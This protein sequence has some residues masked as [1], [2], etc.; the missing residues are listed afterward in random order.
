[1]V[2]RSLT[3]LAVIVAVAFASSASRADDGAAHQV[4]QA[5]PIDLGTS[6]GNAYDISNLYCC[7]GTLGALVA[8]THGLYIL[9]NNHVL[10]RTN[11]GVA[12]DPVIQPGMVDTRCARDL[13]TKVAALTRFVPLKFN[14]AVNKV[15]AAIARIVDGTVELSGAVLDIGALGTETLDPFVGLAV[16][17]SGRTTGQT[18]GTVQAVNV[19]L[20]VAYWKKCGQGQQLAYFTN[21]FRVSPGTFSAGG[22]SGS[23]IVEDV[24]GAPRLVGLLFAGSDTDT[25]A[26]PMSAVMQSLCVAPV[27]AA[28]LPDPA[29]CTS[30]GGGGKRKP[31]GG[32]QS[33]GLSGFGHAVAVQAR[34]EGRLFAEAG[35]VGVGIGAGDANNA[36]IEV[37]VEKATGALLARLPQSLDGVPVRVLETGKVF[38]Y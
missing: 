7:S 14:G 28:T 12:G 8:D 6:G 10:A 11:R 27:G 38:A 35:V 29:P 24:L 37:Y 13:T 3:C 5:R 2:G 23:V 30:S 25:F 21:Q 31:R 19:S 36:V 18:F 34:S 22:D 15:D 26:N 4:Y 9:S 17:K 33:R 20:W 16:T 1:M 32:S